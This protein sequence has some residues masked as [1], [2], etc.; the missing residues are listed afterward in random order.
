MPFTASNTEVW[1]IAALRVMTSGDVAPTR[2]T[3]NSIW[4]QLVTSSGGGAPL[5]AAME[6][7]RISTA[8]D[9]SVRRMDFMTLSPGHLFD[10]L[11]S[12]PGERGSPWRPALIGAR[13]YARRCR[14]QQHARIQPMESEQYVKSRTHLHGP[15]RSAHRRHGRSKLQQRAARFLRRPPKPG[16]RLAIAVAHEELRVGARFE[17][18]RCERLP[19]ARQQLLHVVIGRGQGR[20]Q[21]QDHPLGSKERSRIEGRDE[22]AE[23]D[24][25]VDAQ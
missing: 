25:L 21:A 14:A 5:A 18:P 2:A 15:I 20:E 23:R 4:F 24:R 19:R 13:E 17:F 11:S 6:L 10:W 7:L 9:R 16:A 3:R 8:P 22:L 12:S 1:T